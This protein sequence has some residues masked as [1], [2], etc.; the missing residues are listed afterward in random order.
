MKTDE[1]QQQLAELDSLWSSSSSELDVRLDGTGDSIV[2]TRHRYDYDIDVSIPPV[3]DSQQSR[4]GFADAGVCEG[5]DDN[6]SLPVGGSYDP[7]ESGQMR[8]PFQ[9]VEEVMKIEIGNAEISDEHIYQRLTL[10]IDP[11]LVGR[12]PEVKLMGIGTTGVYEVVEDYSYPIDYCSIGRDVPYEV[13]QQ[14]QSGMGSQ[15]RPVPHLCTVTV[16][17]GFQFDRAT[18]PRIFW[19]LISKEDLS[20]VAPLFHDL[21]Y[22]FKGVLHRDWVKPY[23]TFSRREA[24]NLF[25]HLMAK[26]C[27]TSWRVHVAYQAVCHFSAFAWGRQH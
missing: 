1:L 12:L 17:A 21:L 6:I 23:T 16:K 3:N 20:N 24:D 18:I 11:T 22:R 7:A 4:S 15:D 27:V 5:Y 8:S 25:F 13:L 10:K 26:S 14:Y 2:V 19:L 9:S